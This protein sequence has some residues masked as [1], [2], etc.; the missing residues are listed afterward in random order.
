[1]NV[2]AINQAMQSIRAPKTLALWIVVAVVLMFAAPRAW[3]ETGWFRGASVPPVSMPVILPTRN[4]E[5]TPV[6]KQGGYV[7][8]RRIEDNSDLVRMWK[9]DVRVP[10]EPSTRDPVKR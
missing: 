1:M 4:A 5:W 6:L 10:S 3:N 9:R 7:W 8:E 2:D